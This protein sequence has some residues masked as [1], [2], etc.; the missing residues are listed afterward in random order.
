MS[1][2]MNRRPVHST[3]DLGPKTSATY[4]KGLVWLAI[5]ELSYLEQHKCAV[6]LATL[7]DKHTHEVISDLEEARRG[8]A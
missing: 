8:S 3:A 6:L 2:H 4:T 5:T 7:F 1:R